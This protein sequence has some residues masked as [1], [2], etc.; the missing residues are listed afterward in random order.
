MKMGIFGWFKTIAALMP[1]IASMCAVAAGSEAT[2]DE[3]RAAVMEAL[4]ETYGVLQLHGGIKEIK[5]LEWAEISS[6]VEGVVNIT[7]SLS[8]ALGIFK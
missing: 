7:V 6:V 4:G 2:G 8:R 5:N 1:T 3:K